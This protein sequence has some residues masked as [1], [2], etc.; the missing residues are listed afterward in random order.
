M[1]VEPPS[2]EVLQVS[3]DLPGVEV[4]GVEAEMFLAPVPLS[5]LVFSV[6]AINEGPSGPFGIAVSRGSDMVGG[7]PEEQLSWGCFLP[8][9]AS[10]SHSQWR[11]VPVGVKGGGS[12]VLPCGGL[13]S[14]SF[15][16]LNRDRPAWFPKHRIRKKSSLLY[17]PPLC[18]GSPARSIEVFCCGG[19][20]LEVAGSFA[21]E[22]AAPQLL[23]LRG[24]VRLW[25]LWACACS[26]WSSMLRILPGYIA[27]VGFVRVVSFGLAVPSFPDWSP[28]GLQ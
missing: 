26:C 10:L 6:P 21:I 17:T 12:V 1:N 4:P 13:V 16:F 15:F 23:G 11:K 27:I 28:G 20:L 3:G 8:Y 19:G 14:F 25:L 7:V 9:L 18:F 24:G 22:A 2:E 5:G